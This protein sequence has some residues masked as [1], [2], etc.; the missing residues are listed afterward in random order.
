MVSTTLA[1]PLARQ[2]STLI[3]GDVAA[4]I[5][6][7]KHQD[8]RQIQVIGSGQLVQTLIQDRLAD[9]YRLMVHPILMGAGKAPLPRA[10][11]AGLAPIGRLEGDRHRG[12]DPH[13]RTGGAGSRDRGQRVRLGV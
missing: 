2:N 9:E 8:G 1:A 3:S 7:L 5:A 11:L 10:R 6:K 13:L 12:R 4:E